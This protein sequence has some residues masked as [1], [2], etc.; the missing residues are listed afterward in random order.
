MEYFPLILG[1]ANF[2]ASVSSFGYFHSNKTLFILI[3]YP[4]TIKDFIHFIYLNL[5]IFSID[6]TFKLRLEEEKRYPKA[7]ILA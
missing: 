6:N 1:R 3:H 4:D 7:H 2:L 5:V